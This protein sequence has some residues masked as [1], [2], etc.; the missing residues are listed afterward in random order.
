VKKEGKGRVHHLET[1]L[2]IKPG[3]VL[4]Y[5]RYNSPV[6]HSGLYLGLDRVMHAAVPFLETKG[7]ILNFC[8]T[9]AFLSGTEDVIVFTSLLK[10]MSKQQLEERVSNVA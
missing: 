7:E 9:S 5:Y 10:F 2:A 6:F 3:S 8:S 4:I 1:E